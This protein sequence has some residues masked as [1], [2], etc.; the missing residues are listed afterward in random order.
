[1]F[2]L[3]LPAPR[4]PVKQATR[5]GRRLANMGPFSRTCANVSIPFRSGPGERPSCR[6]RV[7]DM[8]NAFGDTFTKTSAEI[9]VAVRKYIG[10]ASINL[11]AD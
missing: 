2:R 7:R 11:V 5:M 4:D 1:M 10:C 3:T 6:Q 8:G 9:G